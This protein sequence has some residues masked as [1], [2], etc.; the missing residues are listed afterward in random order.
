MFEF[1]PLLE[2]EMTAFRSAE[3]EMADVL[4]R[5]DR[6]RR[7]RRLGSA[8]LALLVA[9]LALVALVRAFGDVG[10]KVPA[11]QPPTGT[12][13]FS[14]QL[15]GAEV[16]FLFTI[17]PDG[18]KQAQ[19]F[20][21]SSDTFWVS[22]DGSRLL[23]AYFQGD[24]IPWVKPGVVNLDGTGLMALPIRDDTLSGLWPD[25]W[26]PDGGRFVG[27]GLSTDQTSSSK[28]LY[29]ART[30]DGGDLT[31]VT[32]APSGQH[33][34]AIG[35][36]SDGS[37]ILFLRR[38]EN[39]VSGGIHHLLVVNVDG[40]GLIQLN[41]PGTRIL[42]H[43]PNTELSS[44]GAAGDS[45]NW[46]PDGDQVTFVASRGEG[47]ERA[48]FVLGADGTDPR[49]IT[50][51]GDIRSP[52]WSPDDAWIAYSQSRRG[53]YDLFIVHPDGT[54]TRQVT[55]HADGL[56]SFGGVWSPDGSRLLFVRNPD[57]DQF[58]SSLWIVKVDGSGL[59]QV[60]DQLAEYWSYG[61]SPQ[62]MTSKGIDGAES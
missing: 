5:S 12:I 44:P 30:S 10:R 53:G 9:G 47:T 33:D 39:D 36:S 61:W 42:T 6:R 40:S 17:G 62:E 32:I 22:P 56:M 13:V 52:H 46:S 21:E 55:S 7:N 28:G 29:T 34:Y 48:I 54:G 41:P 4:R 23:F 45:A 60:T 37:K 50:P 49:R 8:V 2:R 27:Q 59:V 15:A 14:S 3:F 38:V 11:T 35:Y 43:H 19:P 57:G 25:A 51:W 1:G 58:H 20:P 18:S 26:S 31:Q 24:Q 16:D